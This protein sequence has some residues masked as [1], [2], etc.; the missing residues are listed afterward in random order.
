MANEIKGLAPQKQTYAAWASVNP[1]LGISGYGQIVIAT[2]SEYGDILVWGAGQKFNAAFSAGQWMQGIGAQSLTLGRKS[3]SAIPT[4]SISTSEW[5]TIARSPAI[6]N[7]PS[8]CVIDI[9]HPS[10]TLS[11][12]VAFRE[13]AGVKNHINTTC[14]IIKRAFWGI[15][16]PVIGG[17]R[18]A[19]SDTTNNAGSEVQ[20]ELL[21]SSSNVSI[22]ISRN[23]S[24][25]AYVGYEKV[26]FEAATGTLP[27]G[28]TVATYLEAGAK[29]VASEAVVFLP[30]KGFVQS[31][32][33]IR[34]TFTWPELPKLNATVMTWTDPSVS[35]VATVGG[36]T[37]V[38]INGITA[39][40]PSVSDR[41][42]SVSLTVSNDLS[43]YIGQAISA[44][45]TNGTGGGITLS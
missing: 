30:I 42:I 12:E 18:L 40:T 28:E 44:F 36:V 22:E 45:R 17:V 3:S 34:I 9:V 35:W 21:G 15:T 24:Y 8:A 4:T 14:K 13:N 23:V 43:S 11:V 25:Y 29:Y 16:D 31:Q 20:I 10:G 5:K 37:T 27:D 7:L 26:S 1:T 33:V 41:E 32:Y 2:G 39:G 6:A 38:S 19:K